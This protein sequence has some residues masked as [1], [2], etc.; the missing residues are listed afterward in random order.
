MFRDHGESVNISAS[1][2][3]VLMFWEKEGS[4][5]TKKTFSDPF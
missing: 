4:N 2:K 5:K 1:H 3:V